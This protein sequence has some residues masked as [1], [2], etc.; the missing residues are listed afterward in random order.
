MGSTPA[1][2]PL[3]CPEEDEAIRDCVSTHFS[4]EEMLK[5]HECIQGCGNPCDI[6]E[7][8]VRFDELNECGDHC[9][10]ECK[11]E[12]VDLMG[13]Y[14]EDSCPCVEDPPAPLETC[15]E[16]DEVGVLCLSWT[17]TLLHVSLT[18]FLPIMLITCRHLMFAFTLTLVM[19]KW[20]ELMDVLQNVWMVYA[21]SWIAIPGLIE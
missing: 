14:T 4:D 15:P 2:T 18:P 3:L 7:C 1:P 17:L 19:R 21:T 6:D 16:E 20:K 8:D 9:I 13:C 11:E 12:Y 10:N 5:V